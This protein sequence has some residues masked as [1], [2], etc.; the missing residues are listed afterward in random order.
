[1]LITERLKAGFPE[2][3]SRKHELRYPKGVISKY[4]KALKQIIIP[5]LR[6]SDRCFADEYHWKDGYEAYICCNVESDSILKKPTYFGLLAK[7]GLR[8]K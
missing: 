4:K 8:R 7:L 5:V 2:V 6:W 1:M 3:Q